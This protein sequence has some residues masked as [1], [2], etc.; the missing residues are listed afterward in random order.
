MFDETDPATW[1]VLPAGY[2]WLT[3]DHVTGENHLFAPDGTNLS[4]EAGAPDPC[5]YVPETAVN[6]A[7][8]AAMLDH[9]H[10]SWYD[11]SKWAQWCDMTPVVHRVTEGPEPGY[12]GPDMWL[13]EVQYSTRGGRAVYGVNRNNVPTLYAD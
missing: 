9:P 1:G 13:I 4:V 12:C 11:N 7:I 2:W 8:V 6:A 5:P 10:R 3:V